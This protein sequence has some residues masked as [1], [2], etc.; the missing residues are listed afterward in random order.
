MLV[1]PLVALGLAILVFLPRG[2]TIVPAPLV[3][4]IVITA[5]VWI[6]GWDLPD[7]ADQGELPR[8]LPELFIPQVPLT[9][10]TLRIIAQQRE[11]G[12]TI[13][14]VAKDFG[15]S[16]SCLT[17]WIAIADRE[18]GIR[19]GPTVA[20]SVELRDAKRRIRLLEQENEVLRRAAAYL[21]QANIAPN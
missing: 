7:V 14:Q 19:P 16:E 8:S 18:A 6:T 15:I 11:N 10:E 4:I 5:V 17:N 9:V 2:T 3:T 12:V 13:K 20:E 21:S 1:Y